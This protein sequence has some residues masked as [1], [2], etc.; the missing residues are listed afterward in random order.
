[1]KLKAL[2]GN[3]A[4]VDVQCTPGLKKNSGAAVYE[5]GD[6]SMGWNET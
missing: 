3:N 5:H 1:M 4:G 2:H 6:K